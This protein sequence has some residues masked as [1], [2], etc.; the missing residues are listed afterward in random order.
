MLNENE[1]EKAF[2]RRFGPSFGGAGYEIL[3][4]MKDGWRKISSHVTAGAQD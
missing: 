1:L 4:M 3:E 2:H